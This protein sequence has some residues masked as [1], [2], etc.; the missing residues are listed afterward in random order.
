M[1][2]LVQQGSL[3]HLRLLIL[4]LA[5]MATPKLA[6]AVG[7]TKI[8]SGGD[9]YAIG[10]D[11]NIYKGNFYGN[12]QNLGQVYPGT[13]AV[14]VARGTWYLYVLAW[15]YSSGYLL[16][17]CN[18]DLTGC[19][20]Q[21]YFNARN[22]QC[23]VHLAV[24]QGGM[25]EDIPVIANSIA[26]VY[27]WQNSNWA[28]VQNARAAYLAATNQPLEGNLY[29]VT[30]QGQG[31][32]YNATYSWTTIAGSTF[33]R[34]ISYPGANFPNQALILGTNNRLYRWD[35]SS[36]RSVGQFNTYP[37]YDFAQDG[38]GYPFMLY[39]SCSG[40]GYKIGYTTSYTGVSPIGQYGGCLN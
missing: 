1:L 19:D 23:G 8:V 16:W 36:N 40:G 24:L 22:Q 39:G 25:G 20:W 9:L 31:Y 38:Y 34:E 26:H 6:H 18:T 15:N 12:W 7:A 14:D 35:I 30:P 33:S 10:A 4:A 27:Q 21:Q 17:R 2:K 28:E 11:G 29:F 32:R 37:V 3:R 5:M 13:P